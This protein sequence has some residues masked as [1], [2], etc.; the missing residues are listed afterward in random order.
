MG[1]THVVDY[2]IKTAHADV[3]HADTDG[4]TALHNA[5]ARG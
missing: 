1:H 5:A 2:L 4:W 3:F